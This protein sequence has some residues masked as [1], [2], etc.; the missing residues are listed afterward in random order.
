MARPVAFVFPGQGSQRVGMLDAAPHTADADRLL[1]AAEAL[2]GRPLAQI[3]ADGPDESLAD[4]RAAQPLLYLAG[5][6]WASWLEQQGLRPTMVAGHSL[7]ELTALAFAGVFSVEAGLELVSARARIMARVAAEVPGTMAAVIGLDRR[8]LSELVHPIQGV[9]IA[10]D[11]SAA[12][13]VLSGTHEG[14]ER[15]VEALSAAGA[16]RI[17]PLK[18]AGP[19]H[20]PLMQPAAEEFASVI[21]QA[22]FADARVPVVQNTQPSPTTNAETIRERLV[23]QITSPV[24]WTETME[25]LVDSGIEILVESGPGGVLAGLARKVEGLTALSAEVDGIVR[26]L[27]V[28][29]A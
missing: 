11:N 21:A 29:G 17:V 13:V 23:A 25:T 26:T 14:I 16:R 19:F 28:V 27:E 15:A 1:D 20:S 8:T 22:A 6:R 7:G 3:A 5:W 12:Q 18:V 2:S 10:N 24:R 9:W 4:T